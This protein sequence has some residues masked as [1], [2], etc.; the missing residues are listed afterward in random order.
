MS[1]VNKIIILLVLA[2]TLFMTV[3]SWMNNLNN[4]PF[5]VGRENTM[6]FS[7]GRT[8]TDFEV[9]S[10][11]EVITVDHKFGGI[12]DV[13]SSIL[14]E[15]ETKALNIYYSVNFFGENLFST[16]NALRSENYTS[17]VE[18]DLVEAH[19]MEGSSEQFFQTLYQ[20][21]YTFCYSSLLTS[22][23]QC[24]TAD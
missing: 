7:R 20:D 22:S 16:A 1:N 17:S 11:K 15:G 21:R 6:L 23:V 10:F 8:Y 2:N 3:I 5:L 13:H 19:L 9:D 4:P 12:H 18:P 24:I 14:S